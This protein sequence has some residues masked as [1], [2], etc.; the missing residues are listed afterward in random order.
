MYVPVEPSVMQRQDFKFAFQ[1]KQL[2]LH[3]GAISILIAGYSLFL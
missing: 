2:A 3:A 1:L